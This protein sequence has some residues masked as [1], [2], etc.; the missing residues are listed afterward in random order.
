MSYKKI[1]YDEIWELTTAGQKLCESWSEELGTLTERIN[2]LTST[3][4]YKG[5]AANSTKNYFQE[6]HSLTLSSI[7]QLINL[8]LSQASKYYGRYQSEVDSGD[9]H[10]TIV[11]KEVEN[12]GTV[13]KR[14]DEDLNLI[15][16]IT[17]E[18]NSIRR[19][20]SHLAYINST[21]KQDDLINGLKAALKYATDVNNKAISYENARKGDFK[22]ID[23]IISQVN[24]IICSQLSSNRIPIIKYQSG[25]I[26]GMCN[27]KKLVTALEESDQIIDDFINSDDYESIM[28]QVVNRDALIAEE[29]KKNREW[30]KWLA[31]G[32][33][34]VGGIVLTV[35]TAGAFGVG[36]C[37]LVGAAVGGITAATSKLADEYYEHGNLEDMDWGDFWTE[38]AAGTVVGGIAGGFG[39]VSQG[40]AVKGPIEAGLNATK[41][42]LV[43]ETADCF[44]RTGCAVVL[45]PPDG[46]TVYSVFSKEAKDIAYKGAGAFVGGA[47]AGHYDIDKSDKSYLTKLKEKTVENVAQYTTEGAVKVTWDVVDYGAVRGDMETCKSVI[48][49]DL[50]ETAGDLVGAEAGALASEN[51]IKDHLKHSPDAK[52]WEKTMETVRDKALDTATDTVSDTMKD[53]AK[54]TY[55]R[56]VDYVAGKGDAKDIFGKIIEDDLDN[57]RSIAK[58]AGENITKNVSKEAVERRQLD[59]ADGKTDGKVDSVK[60]GGKTYTKQD[61]D[62]IKK[63]AGKGVYKNETAEDMLGINNNVDRRTV[64][65]GQMPLENLKNSHKGKGRV[66]SYTRSYTKTSDSNK[67][68]SSKK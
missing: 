20:I 58:S 61:Y 31:V 41:Q 11:A 23:E 51:T 17:D 60:V 22:Q 64:K 13:Y 19:N 3:A 50:K 29:D 36:A 16:T 4:S 10:T 15:Y 42:K 68:N 53:V 21:P 55:E 54:G 5:Q 57:G 40:S 49:E 34:I 26:A 38:V 14:I 47:V 63:N 62:A 6:V 18:I 8:Y 66:E 67:G 30:A 9:R 32:V 28:T 24:Q 2:T 12:G 48:Y 45:G 37:V 65:T 56:S 1:Y 27:I 52:G 35:V 44:V 7:C 33:A 25:Q 46:E 39:A 43:E 59:R